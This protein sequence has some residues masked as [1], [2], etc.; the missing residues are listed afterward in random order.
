MTGN[1]RREI[2]KLVREEANGLTIKA[3]VSDMF[4]ENTSCKVAIGVHVEIQRWYAD[5]DNEANKQGDRS[6]H[7]II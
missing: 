7:S 4:F 1:N 3:K 6:R 5:F 2:K